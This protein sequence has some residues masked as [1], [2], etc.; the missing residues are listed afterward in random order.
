MTKQDKINRQILKILEDLTSLSNIYSEYGERLVNT[1]SNLI[2][3]KSKK[4][5]V[6]R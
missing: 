2:E 5:K 6:K 4:K 1:L 3:N